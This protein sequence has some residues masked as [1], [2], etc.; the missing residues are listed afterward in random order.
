MCPIHHVK[1]DPGPRSHLHQNLMLWKCVSLRPT[2]QI[3]WKFSRVMQNLSDKLEPG[4]L[5]VGRRDY[6]LPSFER[7][8]CLTLVIQSVWLSICMVNDSLGQV[9]DSVAGHSLATPNSLQCT[10]HLKVLYPSNSAQSR[11]DSNLSVEGWFLSSC[12]V[13]ICNRKQGR[14][15][16]LQV[17]HSKQM[18]WYAKRVNELWKHWRIYSPGTKMSEF[19]TRLR[20]SAGKILSFS[21]IND[22]KSSKN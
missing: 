20:K 10:F 6:P 14:S 7:R 5:H 2:L 4:S 11:S 8:F 1:N 16:L 3:S 9:V 12:H 21:I 15:D 13:Y 19:S 22:I 18:V 17:P